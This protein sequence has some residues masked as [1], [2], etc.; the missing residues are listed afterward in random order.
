MFAI[1]NAIMSLVTE[2]RQRKPPFKLLKPGGT[3]VLG[4][5]E[6]AGAAVTS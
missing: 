1:G 2:P 4:A 3:V 6:K 5:G